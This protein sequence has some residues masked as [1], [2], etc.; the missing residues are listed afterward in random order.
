MLE[1]TIEKINSQHNFDP[2]DNEWNVVNQLIDILHADPSGA[3]LVFHDLDNETMNVKSLARTITG[4]RLRDPVK[5]MGEIC[6]FYHIKKPAEL[7]PEMWRSARIP[8]PTEKPPSK[9][10][11]IMDLL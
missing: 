1:K 6:D 4:K 10:L 9:V 7:P 8:A 2:H 3:E 5:I 11:N